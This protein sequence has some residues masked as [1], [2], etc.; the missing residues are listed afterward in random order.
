MSNGGNEDT[1]NSGDATEA[2]AP[3]TRRQR[4]VMYATAP[5]RSY[6]IQISN[7]I[8]VEQIELRNKRGN[9]VNEDPII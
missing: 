1:I 2:A 8:Q 4:V 3:L 6:A 7:Q 9:V 5:E